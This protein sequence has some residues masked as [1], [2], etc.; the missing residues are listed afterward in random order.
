[1]NAAARIVAG[2]TAA[3][4]ATYIMDALGE[5]MYAHQSDASKQRESAI[6]PTSALAVLAERLLDAAGREA[7]E[8]SVKHLSARIHWAFGT[9]NGALYAMLDRRIS[10]MSKLLAAPFSMMLFVFD[11]L[12]LPAFGLTPAPSAF[13]KETH[14]RSFANHLVYGAVLATV[15]RGLTH[16]ASD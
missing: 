3:A 12:A 8:K 11:E 15:F 4:C 6:E 5:A 9:S 1:M 13:P 2:M 10:V 14:V 16:L 7:S